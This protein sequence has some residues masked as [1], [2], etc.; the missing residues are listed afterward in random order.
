MNL[1]VG[2]SQSNWNR[3]D[4]WLG[5][6]LACGLGVFLLW[7]VL[8]G[9]SELGFRDSGSLYQPLFEWTRNQI[10]QGE[11]PLWCAQDNWGAAVVADA[12]SGV[13]YP[14]KV[15]FLLP[16]VRM[17]VLF[18]WFVLLHL[19]LA[20]SATRWC[21]YECR[22]STW[23]SWLAGIAFAYGGSVLFQSCNVIF[24]ISSAWLP[25]ALGCLLRYR[26][27][28]TLSKPSF[29]WLVGVSISLS[30]MI[31]SGDAQRAFHMLLIAT[32][33]V[34]LRLPGRFLSRLVGCTMTI[35]VVASI[36]FLLSAIQILPT[37]QW[38]ET[39]ERSAIENDRSM[40]RL[41]GRSSDQNSLLS[42]VGSPRSDRLPAGNHQSA[43]Y[44]FS[45]MPWMV[46]DACWPNVLGYASGDSGWG[47]RIRGHDRLW[48]STLYMGWFTLAL[49][50]AAVFTRQRCGLVGFRRVFVFFML[51]SLGWYGIGWMINE[52]NLMRGG[53][54]T[55][56]WFG[57]PTGGVYWMLEIFLPGYSRF[58]Y[59]AKLLS[60]ACLF[61]ALLAGHGLDRWVKDN[62]F[63]GVVQK[64]IGWIACATLML[65]GVLVCHKLSGY[66][67][68][69]IVGPEAT[70]EIAESLLRTAVMIVGC[71]GLLWLALR[72]PSFER[73]LPGLLLVL[74]VF[75]VALNN[76]WVIQTQT[77]TQERSITEQAYR[78]TTFRPFEIDRVP[79]DDRYRQFPKYHLRTEQRV[80]GS[81]S[82]IE[83]LDTWC[84]L[85]ELNRL[86]DTGLQRVLPAYSVDR[87]WQR[88]GDEIV[89][90]PVG[91]LPVAFLADEFR[92]IE[93][94]AVQQQRSILSSTFQARKVLETLAE[95]KDV[96]AVIE[97]DIHL[98]KKLRSVTRG[99]ATGSVVVSQLT[100][101]QQSFRVDAEG[102]RLL[103]IS[104]Y[105]DP[106]WQAWIVKD[107]VQKQRL[108]TFRVNRVL[109]GLIAPQGQY[110]IAYVYRP[111]LF[112]QGAAISCCAWLLITIWMGLRLRR[113]R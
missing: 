92:V 80:V 20:V 84:L 86:S 35:S 75:D 81:Y 1:D 28:M 32:F 54:G 67:L 108:P 90:D 110:E 23:S 17:S 47:Q 50:L 49:G 85:N 73:Q 106:N 34:W 94:L 56:F 57:E 31:L 69:A 53:N 109:T 13:M 95:N 37:W 44:E 63:R 99:D 6:I 26:N 68:L 38:A 70:S 21:G 2:N 55:A 43:I 61:W 76:R 59:P 112:Y 96:S 41:A 72:K 10:W 48:T 89:D 83:P 93:P 8:T 103:V 29:Q 45:V 18:G 19:W 64:V 78:S 30:M 52:L 15:L 71:V 102:K 16:N 51:G 66:Q 36:A 91:G 22:L 58:R 7:P 79:R 3:R 88:Q 107:G 11:L 25:V 97:A 12:T 98:A 62:S 33:L 27:L 24:L 9:Q 46:V 113:H 105:F 101:Q 74:L 100:N 42:A 87:R 60:V 14:G 5:R 65:V 82:S 40:F 39:S 111:A 77:V 104:S 4:E